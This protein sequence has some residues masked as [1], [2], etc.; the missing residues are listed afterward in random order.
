MNFLK[1]PQRICGAAVAAALASCATVHEPV[2]YRPPASAAR[3]AAAESYSIGPQTQ[4]AAL[5]EWYDDGGSGSVSVRIKLSTQMATF[6]RGGREIGWSYV[7]T[8]RSGHRTPAG[9][10]RIMEKSVDKIS[11]RWGHIKDADGNIVKLSARY[12]EPKSPGHR[13]V[14]APMPY[15]MRL[16]SSGVGMHAGPIPTPGSPAS[17]GCIRLP[18]GLAPQLFGAVSVGT[19]VTIV[20]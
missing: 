11:N 9:S 3:S 16:T 10:F 8:G 4:Q 2:A 13:W 15:W 6:Y 20:P 5:Y 18:S 19:P 14:P 12:D 7:A 1:Y 17:A